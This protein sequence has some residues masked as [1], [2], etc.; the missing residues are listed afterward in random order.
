MPKTSLNIAKP[1]PSS[2]EG[3]WCS[4]GPYYAMFPIDFALSKIS[5]YT[6]EGDW[7]LDPFC[8]RGTVPY[9]AEILNRHATGIEISKLGWLYSKV[10]LSPASKNSV[11]RRVQ[12]IDDLSKTKYIN[13]FQGYSEFFQMC[14]SKNVLN[15][16]ITARE[17]L[18]WKNSNV[19]R[20]LMAFIAVNAHG[21][22]GQ[23]LSN[24]MPHVKACGTEYAL[25]WWA[26]KNYSPPELDPLQ[27]ILSKIEWRYSKGKS[28]YTQSNIYL[29]DSRKKLS[30][31]ILK[32][33]K[34]R[35]LF[36]SPPY[37]GVTDYHLDQWLRLWLLGEEPEQKYNSDPNKNNFE[38]KDY[39]RKLLHSVFSKSKNFLNEDAVI[40]V[41]TDA[42]EFSKQ[43]TIEVL[44]E[45]FGETKKMTIIE[46]PFTKRTQTALHGDKSQKPGEVDIIMM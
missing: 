15:F 26:E 38:N 33:K 36:T 45:V 20:T 46:R 8:G 39:Y 32:N 10:K 9:C 21:E 25:K 30:K 16:L 1:T 35:M 5:E 3:R 40:Y 43:T 17:E 22:L 6:N 24:Q 27:I 42:R 11:I 34:Y 37:S 14:Y 31:S 19:D 28:N 41:R 23:T 29:G 2:I 4:F 12:E 7:I 18:D 13:S 44:N